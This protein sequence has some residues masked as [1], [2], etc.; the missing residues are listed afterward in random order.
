[1]AIHCKST[2]LM[3]GGRVLEETPE[4]WKFHAHD[5]KRAKKIPKNDPKQIVFT[6]RSRRVLDKIEKW[7]AQWERKQ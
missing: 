7:M 2:G 6:D 1:M 5:E 4:Y 3:V